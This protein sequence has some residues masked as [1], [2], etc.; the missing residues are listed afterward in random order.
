ITYGPLVKD[1]KTLI[2]E[3]KLPVSLYNAKFLK[4]IDTNQLN[5]IFSNGKSILV[6]EEIV[7]KG[8]L[9]QEILDQKEKGKHQS[10]VMTHSLNDLNIPHLN[11]EEIKEFASFDLKSIHKLIKDAIR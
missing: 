10:L 4:P 11:E 2:E 9:Y 3:T 7:N 6:I 8:G 1:L 5:D